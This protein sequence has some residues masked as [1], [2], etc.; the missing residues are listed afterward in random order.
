[1]A[2]WEIN[3]SNGHKG[4]KLARLDLVPVKPLW[5]LAELYG[6]GALKYTERN[7]ERG[8]KFSALYG[9]MLRHALTFWSGESYD[10]EDGQHH[11]ASVAWMAFALMELEETHSELDDRPREIKL[12]SELTNP[13]VIEEAKQEILEGQGQSEN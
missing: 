11:L 9:A 7:W 10:P 1:V 13:E 3:L 2:S 8:I 12:E 6:R 4:I 5:L